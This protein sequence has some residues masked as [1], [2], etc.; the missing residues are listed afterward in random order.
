[1][2]EVIVGGAFIIA[3]WYVVIVQMKNMNKSAKHDSGIKSIEKSTKYIISSKAENQMFMG[4]TNIE[5]FYI[6]C[7]LAECDDFSLSENKT[8]AEGFASKYGL[9]K[10]SGVENLFKQ[11]EK[12]HC[13]FFRL[14]EE[15]RIKKAKEEENEQAQNSNMFVNFSGHE[16]RKAMLNAELREAKERYKS[17]E[18]QRHYLNQQTIEKER[19][20]ASWGGAV[21]GLTGSTA[22]GLAS[23]VDIEMDNERIRNQNMARMKA[24]MPIYLRQGASMGEV[25]RRINEIEKEIADLP[26]KVISE[27]NASN[28]FKELIL[29]NRECVRSNDSGRFYVSVDISDSKERFIYNSIS[30]VVDGCLTAHVF[31]GDKEV[32][33]ADMS[34]PIYGI[35]NNKVKIFG[36]TPETNCP[37][38]DYSLKFTYKNL[39]EIER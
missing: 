31:D 18:L 11:G 32:A 15:D 4:G 20:W 25:S 37:N 29:E 1:M 36:I 19:N 30:A 13:E 28:I 22:L 2:F 26:K 17:L 8:K 39:W 27:E 23:A 33:R 6:E 24:A 16:K 9:N 5:R 35:T 12:A 14:N 38:K 34:L 21:E 7:V 10:N 3:A